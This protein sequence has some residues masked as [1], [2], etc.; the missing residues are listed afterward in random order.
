MSVGGERDEEGISVQEVN[1]VKSTNEEKFR[2]IVWAHRDKGNLI[3][4]ETY[5]W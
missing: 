3:T 1:T 5:K 2:N 4:V